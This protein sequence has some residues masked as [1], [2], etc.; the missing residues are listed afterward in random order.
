VIN[1]ATSTRYLKFYDALHGSVTVGTTT[2][3]LTIG[4]PGNASDN[5]LALLGLHGKSI[6]FATGLTLAA[7]TGFADNDTGA[8]GDNEVG[9]NIFYQ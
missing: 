7:T 3:L 5:I 2:P 1:R 9:V 8:P 4:I 6:A